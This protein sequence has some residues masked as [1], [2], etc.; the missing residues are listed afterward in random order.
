[1]VQAARSSQLQTVT[2]LRDAC[3]IAHRLTRAYSE[4]RKRG[5]AGA[6]VSAGAYPITWLAYVAVTCIQAS[7]TVHA[8]VASLIAPN[9][10]ARPRRRLWRGLVLVFVLAVGVTQ[11]LTRPPADVRHVVDVL[12]GLC[13]LAWLAEMCVSWRIGHQ[14]GSLEVTEKLLREQVIGP[15]ARGGMFAA[16]PHPSGQ[17]GPLLDEVIEELRRDGVTLLV[18]ARDDELA[19]AYLRHGA[20]RPNDSEPR[21]LV[22]LAP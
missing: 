19:A 4:L 22:W 8:G 6:L 14:A 16:W 1:V 10:V 11:L 21:H 5:R 18:Q 7:D 9:P 17:F 2:R 13:V 12:G 15:V 20:V 3:R